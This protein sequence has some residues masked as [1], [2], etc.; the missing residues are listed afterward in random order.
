M[1]NVQSVMTI[2]VEDLCQ[3]QILHPS[4]S[5]NLIESDQTCE[6][7]L[8]LLQTFVQESISHISLQSRAW[9]KGVQLRAACEKC[10]HIVL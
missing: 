4:N 3:R 7:V 5:T 2:A 9:K 8:L 10:E 1:I 6:N